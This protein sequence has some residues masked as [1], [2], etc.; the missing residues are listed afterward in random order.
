MDLAVFCGE[1][2]MLSKERRV[3]NDLQKGLNKK[4]LL[5]FANGS[6]K[7]TRFV[8]ERGKIPFE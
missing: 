4:V 3:L 2:E 5:R 7:E 8:R 1:L 6:L